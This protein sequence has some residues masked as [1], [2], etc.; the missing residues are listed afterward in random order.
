M[1]P[2]MVEDKVFISYMRE[3]TR[4]NMART[5]QSIKRGRGECEEEEREGDKEGKENQ[6]QSE[7]GRII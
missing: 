3:R 2:G 7:N 4:L 1:L 6:E 5:E